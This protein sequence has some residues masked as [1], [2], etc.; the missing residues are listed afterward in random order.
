MNQEIRILI[1]EDV[2]TDAELFERE[3]RK[4]S[5][6]FTSHRVE[7]E[8]DFIQALTEF[9]P[10]IILSDYQL[11][12]FSGLEALH[13]LNEKEIHIPFILITGTLTEEIAVLCLK[14]GVT[15]YLL[16]SSLMRLP[17]A[18]ES[19]LKRRETEKEKAEALTALQ[20]SQEQLRQAQKLEAVGRL[21]GGIAH[22]FN[23]LLTIIGGYSDLLLKSSTL[24]DND[25]EQLNE[26]DE[27]AQ[28][29]GSLVRQLLAFSRKQVLHPEV[30]NPNSLVTGIG[31]ML[32]RLIGEDIEIVARLD[33]EVGKINADAGQIE[34]VLINL[35]VNARDAMP[36]GGQ[37]TITTQNV[38][39]DQSYSDMHIAVT[40]GPYV[41]LAVS[42]T[43]TG[44]DAETQQHIFE[45]FFT[46][47]EMGKGTGL[48]LSTI[49]G[50]VKQ[51]GGNICVYSEIGK[52]TT[53]KIYLPRVEAEVSTRREPHPREPNVAAT[54]TILLVEDEVR[55]RKLAANILTAR[56]Y[57]V[58]TAKNGAEAIDIS[59]NHPGRIDLLLTDVVMPGMG[60]RDV[61]DS[62]K[63]V[64]PQMRVLY[65][66]GYTDD[67]ILHH[68]VLERRTTF[69]EKP[70]TAHKLAKKV[71]EVLAE[72]AVADEM[73]ANKSHNVQ[74]QEQA[75]AS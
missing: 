48:G 66:S 22:D 51:S 70:F 23:N 71:R 65:M 58:L 8:Q 47:K 43:G 17:S 18:V 40:P 60:G 35:V 33:H 46:T 64:R 4:A 61:A 34:Q 6:A 31:R 57:Y 62:I 44:M 10:D 32:Q 16:K 9:D 5:I 39:L 20:E 52:G 56:G 73:L 12:Q 29:A 49:Y 54:E 13:L 72:S 69:I 24:G 1:L 59:S 38:D 36:R 15:D 45:P 75:A 50:I 68:G 7:T 3:L 11:P 27:A 30:L 28:R 37:I 53:F 42:D 67:A 55:I 14:E 63:L 19:A 25:R 2:A 21:A 74:H 41:M 26:I